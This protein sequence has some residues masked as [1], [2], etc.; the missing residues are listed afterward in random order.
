MNLE[1]ITPTLAA[2]F[3][4]DQALAALPFLSQVATDAT[5][6]DAVRDYNQRLEQALQGGG[7]ALV[8]LVSEGEDQAPSAPTLDLWNTVVICIV[9]NAKKNATGLTAFQ[10][11]RRVLR[12]LKNVTTIARTGRAEVR[13]GKPAYNVGPLNQGTTVYFVNALVRT[14]EPIGPVTPAQP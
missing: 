11:T 3:A 7:L 10:L 6:A 14:T 8:A 9:E 1:E 2:C 12:V 4:R 5:D 13:L